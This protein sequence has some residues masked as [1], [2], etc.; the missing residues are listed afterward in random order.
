MKKYK[1][2]FF[3]LLI[4]LFVFVLANAALADYLKWG[5]V[6]SLYG[7][8]KTT[9]GGLSSASIPDII[10]FVVSAILGLVSIAFFILFVYAGFRWMTAAGNEEKIS[11]AKKLMVN[12]VIGL[13]IVI[14]A[15]TTTYF[16]SQ[17]LETGTTGGGAG[18]GGSP[19]PT[20]PACY[21]GFCKDSCTSGTEAIG[22]GTCP[23][24]QVCCIKDCAACGQGAGGCDQSSCPA[25]CTF[26][27][28]TLG[29]D[30]CIC[31]GNLIG[32]GCR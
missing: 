14:T 3:F 31:E 10:A 23:N 32:T 15:Y 6:S 21:S 17:A 16:I 12:S 7:L 25:P 18:S 11:K 13:A 1:A 30:E 9:A 19:A 5:N 28:R 20:G 22:T 29:L 4:I 24:G 8:T 26:V 2:I 27:P